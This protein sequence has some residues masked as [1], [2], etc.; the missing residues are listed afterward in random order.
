MQRYIY[1]T[2]ANGKIYFQTALTEIHQNLLTNH[3]N[4]PESTCV[5]ILQ[6][7]TNV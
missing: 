1:S 6:I 4:S 3:Q 2:F 7:L 5:I